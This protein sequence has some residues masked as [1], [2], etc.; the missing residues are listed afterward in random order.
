MVIYVWAFFYGK[1]TCG[2]EVMGGWGDGWIPGRKIYGIL[3]PKY[4]CTP[5]SVQ[6]RKTLLGAT[7]QE[8]DVLEAEHFYSVV[9]KF[10][11]T[12]TT[13]CNGQCYNDYVT[14]QFLGVSSHYT[15]PDKCV[16][17]SAM[18]WG[19]SFCDGD[20]EVC[21]EDLRCPQDFKKYTMSTI[22]V[23]SYCY[24]FTTQTY[25]DLDEDDGAN[26]NIDRSDEDIK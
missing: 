26:D 9:G 18:C 6:S 5:P 17:W 23:R 24:G 16:H 19:V 3:T 13:P 25:G 14:S 21:G 4:C 8:G 11:T 1:C 12:G 10:E 22:P 2:D 20:E 7:C 15:C